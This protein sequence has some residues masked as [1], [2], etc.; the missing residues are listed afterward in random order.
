MKYKDLILVLK[1]ASLCPLKAKDYKVLLYLIDKFEQETDIIIRQTKIGTE[2]GMTKS[3]VSRAFS[4]LIEQNIIEKITI[5]II[6][7]NSQKE[8][9]K[10]FRL[11]YK[12]KSEIERQCDAIWW[13]KT[14][15]NDIL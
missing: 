10:G 2:L 13:H 5:P 7:K 14:N 9:K 6:G 1:Y 12:T 4:H 3:E 11:L 8:L 15:E